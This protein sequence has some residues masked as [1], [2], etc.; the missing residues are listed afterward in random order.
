[1]LGKLLVIVK[2]LLPTSI[3]LTYTLSAPTT[4]VPLPVTYTSLYPVRET[5]SI[6]SVSR[7]KLLASVYFPGP[8]KTENLLVVD[9]LA[10]LAK[11]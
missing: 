4:I 10:V 9:G 1:V 7:I 8:S 5:T 3:P 11:A 2:L 6:Y